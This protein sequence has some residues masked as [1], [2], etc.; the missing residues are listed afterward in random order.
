MNNSTNKTALISGI[1]GQLGSWLAELLLGQEYQVHGIV[2]RTTQ[3]S[4]ANIQ[5]LLGRQ[6]ESFLRL[7][8]GDVTDSG[9]INDLLIKVK[10]DIVFNLAAQSHVGHSFKCP[11]ATS[12]V[13]YWGVLNF[14][15]AIRHYSP[16]TRF[17]QASTSEMF[18]GLSSL[19]QSENSPFHPRSPYSVSKLAAH[20]LTV[21]YRESYNLWA[22]CA[23]FF[24][25]ESERRGLEFVTRKA[26]NCAA[27]YK[28]GLLKTKTGF[29]NIHSYRDWSY[30]PDIMKGLLLMS[31]Q[32]TAEE[33]VFSSGETHCIKDMLDEVFN[34]AGL[35]NYEEYIYIDPQFYRPAEVDVLIG[36]SAKAKSKLAWRPQTSFIDMIH[37]MYNYDLQQLS[38]QIQ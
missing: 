19:P 8:Q 13:N 11:A 18:G 12:D 15:E 9:F 27:Q 28:L 10:P 16:S 37:L 14:L 20:W 25:S 34:Y 17:I 29:G 26:T 36:D 22:A 1:T 2:R 24:N 33:F 23:I 21:N 35:G 6:D 7:H 31:E 3:P 30:A 38:K 5:H 32:K 4:T